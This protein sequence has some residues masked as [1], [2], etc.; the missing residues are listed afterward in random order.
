MGGVGSA[1]LDGES[2]LKPSKPLSV[3]VLCLLC[4]G[5]S[6]YVL[7]L[8]ES[9]GFLVISDQLLPCLLGRRVAYIYD[10]ELR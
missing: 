7:G 2:I 9:R 3:T 10:N 5:Y 1:W 6:V 8:G 4:S